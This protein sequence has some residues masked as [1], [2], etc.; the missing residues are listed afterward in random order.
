[1]GFYVNIL[2][3]Q[4]GVCLQ[5]KGEGSRQDHNAGKLGKGIPV[6][7]GPNV[8]KLFVSNLRMVVIDQLECL[9]L[10]SFSSLI[11]QTVFV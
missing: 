10:A 7:P 9:S 2:M 4:K 6:R 8:I 1:M 5:E 11:P 3:M